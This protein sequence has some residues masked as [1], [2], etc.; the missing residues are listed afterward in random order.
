MTLL[1][2]DSL[3]KDVGII[4]PLHYVLLLSLSVPLCG[5]PGMCRI[6][7]LGMSVEEYAITGASG[8]GIWV[9]LAFKGL[10]NN[11]HLNHT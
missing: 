8:S 5:C 6:W 10:F 3:C 1:M 4:S 2:Q 9:F 11:G 7:V